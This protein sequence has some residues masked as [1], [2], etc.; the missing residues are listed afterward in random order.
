MTDNQFKDECR[1]WDVN[2]IVFEPSNW[3]TFSPMMCARG[4]ATA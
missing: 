2:K 1:A 3:K 4:D